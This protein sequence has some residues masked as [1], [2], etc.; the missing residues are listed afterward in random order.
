M[1]KDTKITDDQMSRLIDAALDETRQEIL[2]L[3]SQ[4]DQLQKAVDVLE[5]FNGPPDPQRYRNLKPTKLVLAIVKSRNKDWSR[6]EIMEEA[7]RGGKDLTSWVNAY[8]VLQHTEERL[9]KRGK[10]LKIKAGTAK[11][12]RVTYRAITEV[13]DVEGHQ[14]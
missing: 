13:D 5:K 14:D 12:E 1:S 6:T 11:H 10:I 3:R 7:Q 8:N 2:S 4:A 9:A